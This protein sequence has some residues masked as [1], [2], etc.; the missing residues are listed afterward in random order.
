MEFRF[1]LLLLQIEIYYIGYYVWF[2]YL[3]NND[4]WVVDMLKMR[5]NKWYIDFIL[6]LKGSE[7]LAAFQLVP[8]ELVPLGGLEGFVFERGLIVLV[9]A[10]FAYRA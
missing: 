10:I 9:F 4:S 7:L 6:L 5:E 1:G 3:M 2:K 8:Y